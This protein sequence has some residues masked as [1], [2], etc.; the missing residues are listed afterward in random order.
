MRSSR[1]P[2]GQAALDRSR[3]FAGSERPADDLRNTRGDQRV[4][5]N[6]PDRRCCEED[7]QGRGDLVQFRGKLERHRGA[8]EMADHDRIKALWPRA[9]RR[10]RILAAG[11]SDRFVA[12][13]GQYLFILEQL[14]AF[15]VDDLTSIVAKAEKAGL[16]VTEDE[17][18]EGCDRR[19]VDDPFGNRIELIEPHAK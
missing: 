1:T 19:H 3:D 18:I 7:R 13:C 6:R 14:A 2:P 11:K 8:G 15:I 10:Q 17:P 9:A 12:E 5:P 4:G 16:R